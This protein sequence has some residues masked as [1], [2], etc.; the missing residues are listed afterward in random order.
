MPG[1][2]FIG[3]VATTPQLS[4][5]V[6]ALR[7][8]GG[9][10]EPRAWESL[11]RDWHA[12][13]LAVRPDHRMI[14]HTAFLVFARRL[15]DG[16]E[17]PPVRRRPSKGMDT[18]RRRCPRA[19]PSGRGTTVRVRALLTGLLVVLALAPVRAEAATMSTMVLRGS[20]SAS[21][22][23]TFRM[24]ITVHM[25]VFDS[26]KFRPSVTTKGTYAG[27]WVEQIGDPNESTGFYVVPKTDGP[28]GRH[29]MGFDPYGHKFEPGRYR[30]TLVTDGPT[31]LRIAVVGLPRTLTLSPTKPVRSWGKLVD[32]RSATTAMHGQETVTFGVR[33]GSRTMLMAYL[34]APTSPQ[35]TSHICLEEGTL[36]CPAGGNQKSFATGDGGWSAEW[37]HFGVGS[38]KTTAEQDVLF[39]QSAPGSEPP[40]DLLA[41]VVTFGG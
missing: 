10:T 32:I 6:E 3:Y 27:A 1:G 31:E 16:V 2:V 12:D 33:N 13:G 38:L 5:L 35:M 22:D 17:P 30:I 36:P 34:E 9:F 23:V 14:A 11:V 40:K 20:R 8:R 18:P 26:P 29:V 4:E 24:G 28:G 39:L 21:I 19:G 15:A 25:G 37:W 41:F 7:E